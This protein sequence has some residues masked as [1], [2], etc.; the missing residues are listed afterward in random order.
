MGNL[1]IM[2]IVII[3]LFA[4]LN[5]SRM[6][7]VLH[8]PEEKMLDKINRPVYFLHHE[9]QSFVFVKKEQ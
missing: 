2:G 5:F 7:K 4:I 6:P 9:K 1:I 8:F 3:L